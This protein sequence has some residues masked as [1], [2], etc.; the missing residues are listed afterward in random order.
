MARATLANT[1]TA[2][3]LA[4][5]LAG[6]AT[7]FVAVVALAHPCAD[8]A[9]QACRD[10][11]RAQ[12]ALLMGGLSTVATGGLMLGAAEVARCGRRRA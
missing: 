6:A 1:L 5:G 3:G 11:S 7:A 2:L 12:V 10:Q 8:L 9:S 4:A